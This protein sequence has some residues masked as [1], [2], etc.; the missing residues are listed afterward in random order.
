M[1]FDTFG[2]IVDW[3][4]GIVRDVRAFTTAQG[5]QLDAER[6]ADDWRGLYQPAL[7]SVRS[8]ARP[9]ATLDELHSESLLSILDSH[10]VNPD[11]FGPGVL[12]ELNRSW[13]HLPAWPDSIPGLTALRSRYIIGPLSN[14]NTSLLVNMAKNTGLPWDVII[15]SDVT[16]AYK[17][18]PESYLRTAA[19]LDL[20]P[21][22]L[23]LVAAHNE[24]LDAAQRSGLATAFIPRSTEHGPHQ[25][26]DLSPTGAWDIASTSMTDLARQLGVGPP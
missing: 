21:G 18:S 13:H 19:F 8:G 16:R 25:T 17:P 7:E 2:T 24:D 22:E 20:E 11:R 5:L 6:F 1:C 23:M 15:G 9:F 26:S 3:R 4:T 12:R 10:N 14:G